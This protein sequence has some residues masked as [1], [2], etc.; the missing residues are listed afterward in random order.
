MRQRNFYFL[1][2]VSAAIVTA[3]VFI[4]GE[5]STKRQGNCQTKKPIATINTFM[6]KCLDEDSL[7]TSIFKNNRTELQI[8]G[9]SVL[10]CY[11]VNR[12]F[13]Q[14]IDDSTTV[15]FWEPL[16]I[17]ASLNEVIIADSIIDNFFNHFTFAGVE[18]LVWEKDLGIFLRENNFQ[19]IYDMPN[20]ITIIYGNKFPLKK[21]EL[22]F[23]KGEHEI[24]VGDYTI[25]LQNFILTVKGENYL[26]SKKVQSFGNNML[27]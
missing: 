15:C 19:R 5:Q 2:V 20:S 17:E 9:D 18:K 11:T 13:N 25:S 10:A 27:N 7:V 16:Q 6:K 24:C 4:F 3:L 1:L 14:S 23:G 12:T 22:F 26:F 8:R 21:Q